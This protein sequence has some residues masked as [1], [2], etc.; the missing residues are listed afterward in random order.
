MRKL[1]PLL[2]VAVAVTASAAI[3][4]GR[5]IMADDF[6]RF[7]ERTTEIG[8]LQMGEYE[9]GKRLPV[10]DGE[11][12]ELVRGQD[13]K[14]WIGYS[15]GNPPHDPGVWVQDFTIDDAVIF[16]TVG[17]STMSRNHRAGLSYRAQTPE[18]AAGGWQP[19]AYHVEVA[20]DWSGS[21]DII[22]RY[23]AQRL[24][25]GNVADE[26]TADDSHR[27]RVAFAGAHHQ[28]SVDGEMVIDY[29]EYEGGRENEGYIGFGGYYSQGFFDDFE[30]DGA[31]A[32]ET[33]DFGTQSGRIPPLVYQGRPIFVLGTYGQ[34]GEEDLW[35]WKNAGCN[36]VIVPTFGRGKSTGERVQE[37]REDAEWGAT[38]DVAMVYY[39]RVEYFGHDEKQ[40]VPPDEKTIAEAKAHIEQLLSFTAE[41]PNTLGY[42]TVDEIE[43]QLYKAYGQWEEKKDLGL[44]E[45]IVQHM[46]WMYDAYHEGDPDAY[47]MPTIAWWT[48]YEAL[49]PIYD[50]NV[51]NT[52][53]QGEDLF[54]ITYDAICAADAI[55]TTD[56]HS[57]VFMPACYDTKDWP[58]RSRSEL[59][60]SFFAPI[61]NGAMG[62]LPWRLG[63]ASMPYRRAV[64]YPIMREVNRCVP[65]L[66]GEWHN[67]KVASTRHATTAEYLKEL[68]KRVKIKPGEEDDETV[69]V[70]CVP[71]VSH[72]LRR[73]PDNT[74]LLLAAS[75]LREP[76]Q[77]TFTISDIPDLPEEAWEMIDYGPVPM[78]DGKITD[79]FEPFGVRAYRITPK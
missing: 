71:D 30:I 12:M 70:D 57:F 20:P 77:V 31:I 72:C 26:L 22:L 9:W 46:K 14:L 18:A 23:G 55:R 69:R 39:P 63:R 19:R 66:L 17:R 56:A 21:R 79:T 54:K 60:Y 38:N 59:R 13:G 47:V 1:I 5:L 61:I 58:H 25:V 44:S 40:A 50:V 75:N 4:S 33:P 24:A 68:P 76:A 42:W 43:N 28:V 2:C 49:A 41:H 48:T 52:Y 29:W 15:S 51:P 6:D 74:Y 36:T 35:E 37:L 62:L 64:I 78:K 73:R 53:A 65:W 32:Q 10:R 27:L 3:N 8:S 67:E 45:W 11:K 34:P 16:L 7:A